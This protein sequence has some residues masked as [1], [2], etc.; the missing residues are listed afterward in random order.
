MIKVNEVSFR[1]GQRVAL[2]RVSF[3]LDTGLNILL[4]PNGAGKST[5][6]SLL[7]N[8]S[9][10]QQGS[11]TLMGK[12]PGSD[13][14]AELGIVFQQSTLDLDLTVVQNLSYYGALHG[15]SKKH[16]LE[17]A[18]PLLKHFELLSRL[19]DTV[20]QLNGGHR[21][22]TEL[23]RALMHSPSV[24]LLDEPSSGLDPKA[25]QDLTK[26]VRD[27][28]RQHPLCVLW[29]THLIDEASHDD[30]VLILH[31][32]K[33]QAQGTVKA[34]TTKHG[35]RSLSDVFALLT[36]SDTATERG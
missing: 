8:L 5:L 36:R 18:T 34:L 11:L 25:R 29:A 14:M 10:R 6:F 19:N 1:Y 12:T 16:S 33:L 30:N 2:D 17:K 7:A 22:R 21:R 15:F 35:Q 32:G 28:C 23:V 3:R 24:L 9:Q 4:G 27:L 13:T 20:R 26:A 31:Q